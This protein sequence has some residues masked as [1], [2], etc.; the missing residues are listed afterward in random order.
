MPKRVWRSL[1]G[2]LDEEQ[3]YWRL[4]LDDQ[5][6][7]SVFRNGDI[8]IEQASEAYEAVLMLAA[9][10]IQALLL[11]EELDA[12]HHHAREFQTWHDRTVFPLSPSDLASARSL[13]EASDTGKSE[14]DF[15]SRLL[16][17]SKELFDSIREIQLFIGDMPKVI[18]LLKDREMRGRDYVEK[19]REHRNIPVLMVPG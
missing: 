2:P 11:L 14:V 15:R 16:R 17:V 12:V 19:V 13:K 5:S 3:R 10:R 18:Q 9:T 8:S 6:G 4:L 7:L 1:E